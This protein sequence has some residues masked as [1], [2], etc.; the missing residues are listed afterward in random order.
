MFS[1]LIDSKETSLLVQ[2]SFYNQLKP[3]VYNLPVAS[4][5]QYKGKMSFIHS[6]HWT[7]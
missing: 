5:N 7:Y 2:V 4:P 6:E 3:D 1:A